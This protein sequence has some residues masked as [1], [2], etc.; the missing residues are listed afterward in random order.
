MLIITQMTFYIYVHLCTLSICIYL[1][2]PSA[3]S[4]REG[5]VLFT[6]YSRYWCR[7]IFIG[8]LAKKNENSIWKI[9]AHI[10]WLC[11]HRTYYQV[12]NQTTNHT[13]LTCHH[14]PE[15]YASTISY[16]IHNKIFSLSD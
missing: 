3:G 7:Q 16:C 4:W 9:E 8:L 15:N 11:L 14:F 10:G 1:I 6:I 12:Y 2:A 13:K 5:N